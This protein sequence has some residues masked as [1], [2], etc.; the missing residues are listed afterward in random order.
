MTGITVSLPED[1]V[2]RAKRLAERSG[3]PVEDLLAETIELSFRPLGMQ[4][5]SNGPNTDW[6]DQEVLA[7]AATELP[8]ADDVRLSDLLGRQQAGPLAPADRAALAVLMESYRSGLLR[9]AQAL[10]EAVT[11]GLREPLKP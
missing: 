10:R 7:A 4:V 9:K 6:S 5:S 2:E 11:R 3:R 1:V 8:P